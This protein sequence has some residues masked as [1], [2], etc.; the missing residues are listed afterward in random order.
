MLGINNL[1][2]LLVKDGF[3]P[4][5]STSLSMVF[6]IFNVLNCIKKKIRHMVLPVFPD[7]M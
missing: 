1:D 5:S 3:H 4:S 2:Q 7:W 6:W